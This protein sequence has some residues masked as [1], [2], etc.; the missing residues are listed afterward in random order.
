M[1]IRQSRL[2]ELE[3]QARIQQQLDTGAAIASN[4]FSALF[5]GIA[6]LFTKDPNKQAAAAQLGVA[7]FGVAGAAAG[8]AAGRGQMRSIA[9]VE[10]QR[11]VAAEV[12][13]TT[14]GRTASGGAPPSAGVAPPPG[15]PAGTRPAPPTPPRPQLDV[16]VVGAET[17]GEFDYARSVARQ[18]GTATVVN[19]R[20]SEEARTFQQSGGNFVQARVEELPK[21]ARYNLIREDYPFPLGRLFTPSQQFVEA[22][23][24]RLK[25]GGTWVVVTESSEF[26]H[27]LEAA[28]AYSGARV[29]VNQIPQAHEATPQSRYPREASRYVVTFSR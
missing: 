17:A 29:S 10:V 15:P 26:V 4:P 22:R 5:W 9:P 21:G 18:G 8:V 28:G 2:M 11:P 12:R 6:R 24:E 20:A 7:T 16:L 19:P 14:T 3:R 1:N 23:L 13:A 25:P 27:A